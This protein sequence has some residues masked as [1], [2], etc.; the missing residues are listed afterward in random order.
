MGLMTLQFLCAVEEICHIPA[1][2][3][4]V[5]SS[6]FSERSIC[7]TAQKCIFIH[8][9]TGVPSLLTVHSGRRRSRNSCLCTLAI[10]SFSDCFEYCRC[11]HGLSQMSINI[12]PPTLQTATCQLEIEQVCFGT[13][14]V[15]CVYK[16]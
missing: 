13:M 14:K 11:R 1:S 8:L 6:T 10:K 5:I 15:A 12:M 7:E 2:I 9:G 3:A 16:H 4:S